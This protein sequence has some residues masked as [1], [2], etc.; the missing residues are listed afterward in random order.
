MPFERARGDCTVSDDPARLDVAAIHA[1]LAV[2]YWAEGIP[3]PVVEKA[4]AN[5][6]CLGLY[7]G[8]RQVGFARAVT[9]R[10]TYAYV[11]DVYVPTSPT[12]TSSRSSAAA[13]SGPGS[14]RASWSIPTCRACGAWRS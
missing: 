12:S 3:R 2:S 6:L 13:A 10:A 11:A 9:D 7:E 5:S 8:S 1:A 14:S 4:I